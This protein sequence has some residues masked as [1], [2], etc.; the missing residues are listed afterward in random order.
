MAI[1][2]AKKPETKSHQV[3]KNYE[4][5]KI[6]ISYE[7]KN[8]IF[9]QFPNTLKIL[10]KLKLFNLFR[11]CSDFLCWAEF[12]ER[13]STANQAVVPARNSILAQKNVLIFL[14]ASQNLTANLLI[15]LM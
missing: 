15:S 5:R 13:N 11:S 1:K 4:H 14:V 6:S 9:G 3:N 7:T 10:N 12:A 8:Y 2:N